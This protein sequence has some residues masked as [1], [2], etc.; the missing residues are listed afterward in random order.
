MTRVGVS[1]E[2]GG[3]SWA[4]NFYIPP[5]FSV[6]RLLLQGNGALESRADQ[7]RSALFSS[8]I[9][10]VYVLNMGYMQWNDVYSESLKR[11]KVVIQKSE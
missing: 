11:K 9:T 6:K 7:R 8:Q 3:K 2:A 4:K 1:F 10:H 5:L